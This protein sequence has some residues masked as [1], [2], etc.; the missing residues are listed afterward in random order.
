M[1]LLRF[2]FGEGDKEQIQSDGCPLFLCQPKELSDAKSN[3]LT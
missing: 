1:M 2:F 3:R